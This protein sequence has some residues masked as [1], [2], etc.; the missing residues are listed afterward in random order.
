MQ[1]G[2]GVRFRGL[3]KVAWHG[4]RLLSVP[5]P[6][7]SLF[8]YFVFL[9]EHARFIPDSSHIAISLVLQS[10]PRK[11]IQFLRLYGDDWHLGS[12]SR[13]VWQEDAKVSEEIF[14]SIFKECCGNSSFS[15]A[16]VSTQ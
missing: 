13:M 2:R 4:D 6:L 16:S 10:E 9:L 14:A 12:E 7:L 1:Y 5:G 11:E 3:R 15:E 8:K